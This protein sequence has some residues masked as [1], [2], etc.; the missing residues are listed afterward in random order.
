MK[1]YFVRHGHP[2]YKTDS[3]TELG[4]KQAQAAAERLKNCNI[5]RVFASS[6]GRAVRKIRAG[7][8]VISGR[9]II[10]V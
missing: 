8:C 10:M 5:E 2:D 9:N 7:A 3:L 6:K 4:K 1:I